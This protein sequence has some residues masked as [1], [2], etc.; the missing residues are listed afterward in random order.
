MEVTKAPA[1]VTIPANPYHWKRLDNSTN[2][3]ADLKAEAEF[4]AEETKVNARMNLLILQLKNLLN[5]AARSLVTK[6]VKVAKDWQTL[7]TNGSTYWCQIYLSRGKVVTKVKTCIDALK[8]TWQGKAQMDNEALVSQHFDSATR[9]GGHNWT[10][11]E[12]SI[13][14]KIGWYSTN[15]HYVRPRGHRLRL[16]ARKIRILISI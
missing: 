9:P 16:R 8:A 1:G 12:K 11:S 4:K 6:K 3:D 14:S 5:P 13:P 10:G 2:L 15:I 7:K